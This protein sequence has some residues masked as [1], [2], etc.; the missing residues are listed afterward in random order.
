MRKKD[1]IELLRQVDE[2][3]A[4][5]LGETYHGIADEDHARLAQKISRR[6]R[7]ADDTPAVEEENGVIV[8]NSRFAWVRSVTT[9]AAC[10]LLMVGTIT[11]LALLQNRL[12]SP[13]QNDTTNSEGL[14]AV[15]VHPVGE[16]YAVPNLTADGTLWLTVLS[17]EHT[18]A[19]THIT[20]L[21]ESDHALLRGHTDQL[22]VDN[23]IATLPT[24]DGLTIV[25]PAVI[26]IVSGETGMTPNTVRLSDGDICTV[27]LWYSFSDA[28]QAW[29]FS[30]GTSAELPYTEIR[31]EDLK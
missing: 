4:A 2:Q 14:A 21:L 12:P 16:R 23:L 11:G 28:P 10:L 1:V 24:A 25:S 29:R 13:E 8:Q 17:A 30:T 6:L 19:M 5:E 31:T 9:A 26:G 7:P 27:E 22:C 3:S 18:D 20:V 15:Q